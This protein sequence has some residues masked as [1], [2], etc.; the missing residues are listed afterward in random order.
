MIEESKSISR[1]EFLKLAGIAG[2][3]VGVSAGMGG[4]LAACGGEEATT[5]TAG[6]TTT[7]GLTTTSEAAT[8]TTAGVETG[9]EV[10]VGFVDPLTGVLAAF[11]LAGD[12]CVGKWQAAVG[13]GVVLGDGKKHPINMQ[14]V[15]SQSDT[16]RAAQV[17]ADLINNTKVDL[18]M[19]AATGDT[20]NPVADMCEANGMPC[21][22]I[23]VPVEVYV[24]QRGG[25][26]DKPFKWTYNLFWGLTEE[27]TIE[28][29]MFS[30]VQ[31]NQKIAAMWPNNAPGN[32]YRNVYGPS[33]DWKAKGYAFVDGGSYNEPSE[34]FTQQISLFKK[35]G[36]EIAMGVMI[37][38]D[39]TTFTNQC[40]Q[41][42]FKPKIM[43]GI[44]PTLFPTTMEAI[45]PLA[46]GHS[47]VQW[48]HPTYPFK[49][50]LT[51]ETVQEMCDDF[52]KTK[53]MQWQQ[54]IM[55]YAVF[56]WAVDVFKRTTNLDDK[57]EFIKRV[58]ETKMADSLAGPID[59]TAPVQWGTSHP[60]LNCVTT[61]TY[62]GQWRLSSGG[63][64]QFDLVIVSNATT[65]LVTV[66]DKL[67]PM[68]W[69]G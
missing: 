4:L 52:E 40:A 53:N 32:A 69:Q 56:E 59:Y 25:A 48:F 58:Q 18:V 35:D 16:N 8:T 51:G 29:D 24:F 46:D 27:Q 68:T 17:T 20:V 60:T 49:S 10:K 54:T 3:T 57:E 19:A 66:Q 9:R 39:W 64:Y 44:K 11:G 13:D 67:K 42:G 65:P 21:L 33:E 14:V 5:T 15:D 63:K 12:Y 26:P 2:A 7:A 43:Y 23:D 34:D 62:G 28:W 50:S 37:D 47:G 36:C 38:P 55:H 45:G 1:R 22:S 30:Q 61:P 6:P 31:T 41:Q